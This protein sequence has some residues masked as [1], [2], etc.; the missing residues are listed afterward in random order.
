M[1]SFSHEPKVT[2]CKECAR[3][4]QIFQTTYKTCESFLNSFEQVR[5]DRKAQG[6]PTD[7]EQD[8]LRAMLVFACSG[9][10]AV[11]KQLIRDALPNVIE[12]NEGAEQ[13][14]RGF[15]RKKLGGDQKLSIDLIAL[16]ITSRT[17]REHTLKRFIDELLQ[18]SLQSKDQIFQIAAIFDI[19]SNIIS[20]DPKNLAEV[21]K[22]RN[23]IIHELD[24]D[25]GG[26]NRKRVPRRRAD[27]MASVNLIFKTASIFLA[28]V[29]RRC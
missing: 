27:M 28:E 6:T 29:E 14:F 3:S 24:I 20:S 5:K 7:L 18:D 1:P 22:V 23:R 26:T 21:F 15:A 4:I 11:I 17:P 10:D 19:P 16:S 25:F 13:Q 8:L 9:L 12:K 2:A